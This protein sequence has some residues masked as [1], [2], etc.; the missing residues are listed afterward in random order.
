MYL[1]KLA[2]RPWR[3]AP[4]SQIFSAIAVGFLLLLVGFLFWMQHGLKSVLTRLHREQVVTAYIDSS[5]NLQDEN[6]L[7]DAIRM[8]LGA[9]TTTEVKLVNAPQFIQELKNQYPDLGRELEDLGPEMNQ[10]IPR[11]VSVSGILPDSILERIKS[12]PGVE[13]AES[14]KDRFHHII[15]AF[16]TLRWVVRVLIGGVCLALLTGL[17][18]LSRMNAFLHRDALVLLRF[19]GAG[20]GVLASPGMISGL[21]VGLLG[22]LIAWL[23]WLT[24]GV[25]FV[26]HV[27]SFSSILKGMPPV[28][29]QLSV[30]LLLLGGAVGLI[31]GVLG[32]LSGS[33]LKSDGGS[34]R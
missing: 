7:V 5:V 4:L 27:R 34:V 22:G 18:H 19:W 10:V 14:S 28:H 32:S 24:V 20:N 15:G 13:S 17:I 29:A 12:I 26:R 3:I 16:S 23:G 9:Q 8:T 21:F 31:A 2:W 33:Y 6:K 1:L 25:W 11:F 30:S